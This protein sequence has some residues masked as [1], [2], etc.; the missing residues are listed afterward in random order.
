MLSR[1]FLNR[2]AR[3]CGNSI[4]T[5][6]SDGKVR[7]TF[8]EFKN[9]VNQLAN[10]LMALLDVGK[11]D[12][13]AVLLRNMPEYLELYYAIPQIGAVVVPIN[14]RLSEREIEFII[15]N[16]GAA[17]IITQPD[18]IPMINSLRQ[19]HIGLRNF[20]IVHGEAENYLEYESFINNYPATEPDVD[21]SEDDQKHDAENHQ[22][23]C[24]S[25]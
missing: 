12:R 8:I 20:I 5:I 19:I 17:T 2:N 13:V 1:D 6:S 11:G 10:G 3:L 9:R 21:L 18:Y 4:A 23:P 22:A 16:S 14:Y 7:H 24:T 15:K 25:A